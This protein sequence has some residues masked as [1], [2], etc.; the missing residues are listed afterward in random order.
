MLPPAAFKVEYKPVSEIDFSVPKTLKARVDGIVTGDKRQ[1]KSCFDLYKTPTEE[2]FSSFFERLSKN[3]SKPAIL[4]LIPPHSASYKPSMLTEDFPLPLTDLFQESCREMAY[5]ELLKK[6]EECNVSVTSSQIQCVE[7]ATREQSS[8]KKWF[9]YR[10]GRITASKSF[11][12]CRT[13]IASPSQSLIKAIC[14]PQSYVFSSRATLWG[15]QHENIARSLY[16]E[17]MSKCHENFKIEKSGFHISKEFPFIGASPDAL[18][19]CDCCG[20]GCMEIKCPFCSR[21]KTIKEAVDQGKFCL[22]EDEGDIKLDKQHSYFYQI[23]TQLHVTKKDY[24][25]FYVWTSKDYHLERVVKNAET[26]NHIV[27]KS[28]QLFKLCVLPELIGNFY[29]RAPAD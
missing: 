20:S 13:N 12:V 27:H 29:S 14:Y 21:D 23:Q 19:S 18:V 15:C 25:D 28:T 10:A 16:F 17:S 22:I 24:C 5:F 6:C 3:E 2:Q 11:Q 9:I 8:D 1:R 26:W 7:K 4:A